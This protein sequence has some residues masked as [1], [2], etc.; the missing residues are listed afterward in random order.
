MTLPAPPTP[1]SA[2]RRTEPG[3]R[4]ASEQLGD[5]VDQLEGQ[6]D[7]VLAQLDTS[8]APRPR[9]EDGRV[10]LEGRRAS[11]SPREREVLDLLAGGWRVAEVAERLFVSRS[12]VRNHLSQLFRHFGVT[13]QPEL[14]ELVRRAGWRPPA[15]PPAPASG[16]PGVVPCPD[17]PCG[18][19]PP[20]PEQ[21]AAV[22][23]LLQRAAQDLGHARLLLEALECGDEVGR[24]VAERLA[25]LSRQE[26]RVVDL[27]AEGRRVPTI[28]AELGLSQS[29][30]RNHLSNVFRKLGVS[31]QA[32]L[33]TALTR[34]G[35]PRR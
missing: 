34:L 14:L 23:E 10:E 4:S 7:G 21:L 2:R 24:D 8:R 26:R 29:T 22:L 27:V 35:R 1:A 13:S 9:G 33:A 17:G 31:S 19:R 6:L 25:T 20:G 30:V 18:R 28:A 16:A 32:E 15:A 3:P 12:T 11:L 5:L